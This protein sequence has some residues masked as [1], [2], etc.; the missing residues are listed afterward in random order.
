MRLE[1]V[2]RAGLYLR[3][4]R[5]QSGADVCESLGQWVTDI[6]GHPESQQLCVSQSSRGVAH[7]CQNAAVRNV[8]GSATRMQTHTYRHT[9]SAD[10]GVS[11]S[12]SCTHTDPLI[13]RAGT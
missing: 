10:I 3:A 4:Q 5:R 8:I 2:Q 1:A 9:H 12:E 6:T 11:P 13:Q 7:D